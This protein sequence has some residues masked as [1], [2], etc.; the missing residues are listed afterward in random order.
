MIWESKFFTFPNSFI[1]T[2]IFN[3]LVVDELF[4]YINK[5]K[6][7]QQFKDLIIWKELILLSLNQIS[8]FLFKTW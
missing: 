7:I 6:F 2:W 3:N 1:V 5:L 8:F 4:N